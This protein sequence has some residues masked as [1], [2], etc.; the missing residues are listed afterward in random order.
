MSINWSQ[1]FLVSEVW[2]SL[3][4]HFEQWHNHNYKS[5]KTEK[6]VNDVGFGVG[7]VAFLVCYC[8]FFLVEVCYLQMSLCSRLNSSNFTTCFF[9]Y[10]WTKIWGA[11][12]VWKSINASILHW[13]SI[14][15]EIKYQTEAVLSQIRTNTPFPEAKTKQRNKISS[16]SLTSQ[17]N[18]LLSIDWNHWE[19]L[20]ALETR[21]H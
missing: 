4:A 13:S 21:K 9:L 7:F 6:D 12:A 1:N 3:E 5:R 16:K 18:S 15:K 2:S 19:F 8:G 20:E 11:E 17:I 14:W 10:L